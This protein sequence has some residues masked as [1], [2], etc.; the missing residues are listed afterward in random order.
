MRSKLIPWAI[1]LITLYAVIMMWHWPI[2][3][4]YF[5]QLSNLFAAGVTAARLL[6]GRPLPR[7]RYTAAVAVVLTFL[8]FLTLIAP[9]SAD[10]FLAAYAQDHGASL[11]LHLLIPALM[12]ADYLLDARVLPRWR[13]WPLALLPPCVWFGF[14]LLLG[15]LG[16]RWYAGMAAPYPFLNYLAPAGWFGFRPET[17]GAGTAGVGV[18]YALL[19]MMALFLLAG[20]ALTGL[21]RRLSRPQTCPKS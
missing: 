4:T 21:K 2:G 8:V 10:G 17:A 16:V 6:S 18:F 1:L 3:F 12:T 5:T 13:D 20:A 14:I 7:L 11:C 19:A 9:Q 15:A